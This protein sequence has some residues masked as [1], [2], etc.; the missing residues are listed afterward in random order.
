MFSPKKGAQPK[1]VI[2]VFDIGKTNKKLLLFDEQYRVVWEHSERLEETADEDGIPCENLQLL[3]NWMHQTLRQVLQLPSFKLEAINFAAYGASFV[4]VDAVGEPLAPLYN[5]LKPYPEALLEQF[6]QTYGG[7]EAFAI[8]TASPPLGSLNSGLQLY[9]FK[10]EQLMKFAHTLYALHLPQFASYVFT[11]NACSELTSIGCHTAMWDFN[12]NRYHPW[13]AAEAWSNKLPLILPYDTTFPLLDQAAKIQVGI[14]LHD[15]SAALI[16]Y[17]LYFK[18]P[19]LLLST[20]TWCI[21]LNPFNR[22]PLTYDELQQDCLC[23]LSYQGAQVKASRLFA[24]QEHEQQTARIAAH[25]GVAPD[26]YETLSF[27]AAYFAALAS[28]P[29]S[30]FQKKAEPLKQSGFARRL[31]Q[32]F[33]DHAEAYHQLVWDM[34]QQQYAAAML[35]SEGE[36]EKRLFVDGG[37]SR[38]EIYM[39]ALAA[40]FSQWEVFAAAM[41]QATA[42]GAALALHNKWNN[43]ALIPELIELKKYQPPVSMP[44]S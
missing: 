32:E 20:G 19:F 37:F 26:F 21:V 22:Q 18:E 13:V 2:A 28:S 12:Q 11:G 34:V 38:N 25:F 9:R 33:K 42:L 14:G 27:N 43:R 4:Y 8:A 23:Y 31:L 24:G 44:L 30:K 5:Y 6:Y 7:Q 41:P 10:C 29:G 35:V 17:L 40:T 16:P 39:H 36:G 1:Q 15:S 3:R